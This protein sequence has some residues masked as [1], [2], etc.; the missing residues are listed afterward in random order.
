[1]ARRLRWRFT[2]LDQIV[3]ALYKDQHGQ[4]LSSREIYQTHGGDHFRGLEKQ[5]IKK[6]EGVDHCVLSTGGGT[7]I[8]NVIS[9][10]LKNQSKIIYLRVDPDILYRRIIARGIP[11]FFQP[12]QPYESFRKLLEERIP[13]YEG[14]ADLMIDNST[15]GIEHAV[16]KIL[17]WLETVSANASS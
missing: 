17:E 1:L 6:L 7:F 4:K 9:P 12:D 5:A 13:V 2:D 16:G 10:A 15:L 3:E 14:L 11:A 8:Y